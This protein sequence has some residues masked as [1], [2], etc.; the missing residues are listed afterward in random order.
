MPIV[1]APNVTTNQAFQQ[2]PACMP[3]IDAL[4]AITNEIFLNENLRIRRSST[5]SPIVAVPN[6]TAIK[7]AAPVTTNKIFFTNTCMNADR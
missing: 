3:I 1:A 2:K 5:Y 7:T 6:A 4:N